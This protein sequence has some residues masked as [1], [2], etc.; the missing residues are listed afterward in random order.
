MDFE[1]SP[2]HSVFAFPKMRTSATSGPSS[3][4]T[5]KYQYHPIKSP[6]QLRILKL[7]PG[8]GDEP[9]QVKLRHRP[10]SFLPRCEELS[11]E[12]GSPTRDHDIYCEGKI[13]KVTGNL[14]AA[15][16]RLRHTKSVSRAMKELRAPWNPRLLWIGAVCI[17]QEDIIERSEQVK[18]MAN[19]YRTVG[20]TL[21]WIGEEPPLT[22]EA[23]LLIPMLAKIIEPLDPDPF[24]T[25]SLDF[26]HENYEIRRGYRLEQLLTDPAWTLVLDI[27]AS[28]TYFSRLWTV[29]EISLS[30]TENTKIVCGSHSLP[31]RRYR[32]ASVL[33][34]NCDLLREDL[35]Y[36]D[37]LNLLSVELQVD[38]QKR[39]RKEIPSLEECIIATHYRFVTDR[40]DR[41]FG[42]LGMLDSTTRLRFQGVDYS[43]S[44]GKIFQAA[45]ECLIMDSWSLAY[46]Q[47]QHTS[48]IDVKIT[49]ETGIPSWVL[50]MDNNPL[51][52][53]GSPLSRSGSEIIQNIPVTLRDS[54]IEAFGFIFDIA[55]HASDNLSK[56]NFKGQVLKTY[57][58]LIDSIATPKEPDSAIQVLWQTLN[59]G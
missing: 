10:L 27:L 11:Y 42:L 59:L 53:V 4:S 19:I 31:W 6:D 52:I 14:L 1:P 40:R 39:M 32:D 29:Q 54:V 34:E 24:R 30:S 41:V 22:R 51:M 57:N 48:S 56:E 44:L 17:N 2:A 15:L 12:W 47:F 18:L 43:S 50:W 49:K 37:I 33:V 5:E 58:Q 13:L 55:L 3:G 25:P 9:I 16:K 38:L 20:R 28:R 8:R 36:N 7:L 26:L 21:V 35:A 45:T 46:L 23:F